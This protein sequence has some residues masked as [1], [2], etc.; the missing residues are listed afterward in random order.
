MKVNLMKELFTLNYI[1][2]IFKKLSLILKKIPLFKKYSLQKILDLIQ[3]DSIWVLII[4][5]TKKKV[6]F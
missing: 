4:T 5:T 2:D 3:L 6:S 1:M